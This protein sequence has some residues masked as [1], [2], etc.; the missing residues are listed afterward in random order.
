M[1]SFLPQVEWA[2]KN[3]ISVLALNPN[4]NRVNGNKILYSEE[5]WAHCCHIW[6]KYM[7]VSDI[8]N[9]LV[10]SHSAGGECLA[11]IQDQYKSTFY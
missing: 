9:I 1:G 5:P 10:M 4:M 7:E 2:V 3:N 8:E 6:G 11:A